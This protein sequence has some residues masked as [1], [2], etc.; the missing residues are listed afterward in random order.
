M[1]KTANI[2]LF[3]SSYVQNTYNTSLYQRLHRKL[4]EAVGGATNTA[5]VNGGENGT[6]NSLPDVAAVEGGGM[7]VG[8][9]VPA[10]DL[11]WV[12]TR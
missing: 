2:H 9:S 8:S 12:D 5:A 3:L 6:G 1:S 10:L 11:N 7:Q 4:Q